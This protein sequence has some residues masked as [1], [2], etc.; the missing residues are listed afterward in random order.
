MTTQKL[1]V[2]IGSTGGQGGSA[3]DTFLNEP[4]WRVRGITRNPSSA[5]AEALKARG[6]EIVKADL[7]E[8]PSLDAAFQDAHAIFAVSDFWGIYNDPT[9][10]DKL[11]PGEKLNEWAKESETQQLKNVIDSAAKVP[12][13]ERLVVSSLPNIAKL[14]G[15][16]YTDACHFDSKANAEDY[17]RQRHPDLWAKTSVFRPGFFL[18]NFTDLPMAQPTKR[19]DRTVQ[20]LTNL[21]IDLKLPFIVQDEDSGPLVKALVDEAPGKSLVGYRE[22][23]TMREVVHAFNE[24]TGLKAELQQLPL[25]QFGFDCPPELKTEMQDT[26]AFSNE[27]GLEG[28]ND[29][30]LIHPKDLNSPPQ[31]GSVSDW[32]REQDWHKVLGS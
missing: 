9:S 20:F 15:G 24:L 3:V 16:K 14:S 18:S 17:G 5:K 29:P 23:L 25:E 27:F 8:P 11:K 22:W 26:F 19:E 12:T 21:D 1:I 7:D 10:T 28:R 31:L 4:G 32:L 6:V 2:V 13:L 30:T